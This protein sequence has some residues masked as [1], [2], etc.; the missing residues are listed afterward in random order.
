[1]K[2]KIDECVTMLCW[3]D[4]AIVA[5]PALCSAQH[6]DDITGFRIVARPELP[7]V[8]YADHAE[9]ITW[10]RSPDAETALRAAYALVHSSFSI[11]DLPVG[12]TGR[13]GPR[14][15]ALWLPR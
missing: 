13:E 15:S 8:Y 7:M 14:A 5:V 10:S 4:H 11:G 1:M 3:I 6:G 12:P 2:P 9:G